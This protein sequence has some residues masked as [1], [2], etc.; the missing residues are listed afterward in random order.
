MTGFVL[1]H[2]AGT[3][4]W[5]WDDVARR[6]RDAGHDVHAPTLS[7]V[8][9]RVGDGGP[10]TDLSRHVQEVVDLIDGAAL[11]GVVLV[12]FSY[13]GLVISGVAQRL[14]ERVARQVYLDAFLPRPGRCFLDLLPQQARDGMLASVQEGWKIPPA[15][16]SLVGGVGATEPG[17][18]PHAVEAIL[19]R[20]GFHPLGT[21]REVVEAATSPAAPGPPRIYISCTEKPPGDPLIALAGT[22]RAGGWVMHEL[23]TGHFAMLSMPSALAA[24]LTGTASPSG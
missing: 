17:I 9:D 15:P 14:G 19:Q 23:P 3:G 18:A 2:G 22:L 13:G 1:V 21:Y 20:R 5:L 16:L 7:G 11:D 8:G 24:I 6:L 4:G 10:E 12:G